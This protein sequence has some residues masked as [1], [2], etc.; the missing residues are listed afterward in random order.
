M[1][2]IPF[3]YTAWTLRGSRSEDLY[4]KYRKLRK[5]GFF[6]TYTGP[7]EIATVAY[8]KNTIRI[9]VGR[10]SFVILFYKDTG[11][12]FFNTHKLY[13]IDHGSDPV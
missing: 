2:L 1:K 6:H 11:L 3:D 7:V 4:V 5:E 8:N 10:P 12:S 13:L 9:I